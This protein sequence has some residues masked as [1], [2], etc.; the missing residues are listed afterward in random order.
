MKV[1][2]ALKSLLQGVSQQPPRDRLPGQGT[3]QINL[4][5]DPVLGLT[6][7]P[8]TDMV[9]SLG[10]ST[11]VRG[12]HNFQT[13]DGNKYLAKISDGAVRIT[14]LNGVQKT[15]T[16][17]PDAAAYFSPTALF[18][19]ATIDNTTYVTNRLVVPAMLPDTMSYYNAGVNS[20]AGIVQVLGGQYGR[21]YVVKLD[22]VE[23]VRFR[24]VDGSVATHAQYVRT[25]YIAEV[26]E[27][28]MLN[29]FDGVGPPPGTDFQN[30]GGSPYYYGTGAFANGANW[31][32]SRKEDMILIKR[33]SNTT[34]FTLGASDDAGN[35]NLKA[36]T[37]QVPDTSDLPRYA[38]QGYVVRVATE[39]DPEED[40]WL[41][42][43]VEKEGATLGTGFGEQGFWQETVAPNIPY[44]FDL[45]TM[46]H[47]IEYNQTTTAFTVKRGEWKDR[48]VG[49]LVT[50][51]DPSFIGNQ[52]NDVSS[53]QG[54]LIFL[55]GG[56]VIGSRTN[57]YDDFWIGS[58]SAIT[59]SDPIDI[60]STAVEASIMLAA[61]PHNRDL[62]VHSPNG[63]FVVFG[64]TAITPANAALVLTT[65][66]EA[67]L[68]AKPAPAG[69]NIFFAHSYGR[70]VGIRE[71]YTEGGT[72]INDTRPITQHVN[73]YIVG[74][75]RKL[76]SS[77]NYDF[78]IVQTDTDLRTVYVYKYIW[79]DNE[80]VQA[81]W[82]KWVYTDTV[83]YTF[84]DSSVLYVCVSRD[85]TQYLLRQPLD[86][87]N[88]AGLTFPTFLDHR[89]S[90]SGV[91]TTFITPLFGAYAGR[92]LIAVQ[93]A[94]CPNPGMQVPILSINQGTGLVTL[95]Y[96]MGGGD[97]EV[98]IPYRSSYRPT[99]PFIKDGDGVVI[100]SAKL[101]VKNF[102]ITLQQT[103]E[104]I[105]RLLSKHGNGPE[106][107]FQGRIVSDV[108]NVV[109][110]VALSDDK[111][112]MPFRDSTQR[113]DI[114]LFTDSYLPMTLLD[115]EWA[116]QYKK[117]GRRITTGG[118]Q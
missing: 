3:E 66:F 5:S 97:I 21:E 50:N 14:D 13:K 81:S 24:T 23:V 7:R 105:G 40:L 20:P 31:A 55:A 61:V 76:T 82:S 118:S 83:L 78:L 94:G 42:F 16:M 63:Q 69:R 73:S 92:D 115:I 88:T 45:A 95:K 19:F 4:R 18:N 41:H 116:G 39:T 12:W 117:S 104:I 6:R 98:G 93:G 28:L 33:I 26:I 67:D 49:T 1:D 62:T 109:G 51:P 22:G 59:D 27:Y 47:L 8:P 79:S 54:R 38:P 107:K 17:T 91:N 75:V 35:V 113:A 110:S 11:N 90:V 36:M 56:S 65:A 100:A 84:F 102:I 89:F 106:V 46:P 112:Y 70:F 30:D 87:Q 15:V 86:V 103:G 34:K 9:G 32:V 60:S 58:A 37:D 71:F 57:R 80:K 10:S 99:M 53:F 96:D 25:T 114:E 43:N 52:I 2:G 108:N 72:D 77:S 48:Q 68:F 44:K 101:I 29:A 64:R 111:F 85:G 74:N